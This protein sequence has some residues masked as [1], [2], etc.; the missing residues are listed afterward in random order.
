MRRPLGAIAALICLLAACKGGP[1]T[2]PRVVRSEKPAIAAV[3]SAKPSPVPVGV[4]LVQPAR[5]S[6][7]EGIVQIDASYIVAQGG[8]NIVAQGGGNI[9]AQGGGNI[10]S[11]NGGGIVAQGGGNIISGNGS[12]LVATGG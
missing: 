3:T 6:A 9:V 4:K 2:V 8:G 11:T 7:L 1:G 5:T 12:A 10:I